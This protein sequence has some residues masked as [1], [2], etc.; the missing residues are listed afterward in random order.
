[1]DVLHSLLIF[2][3][4]TSS[5][6]TEFHGLPFKLTVNLPFL[7]VL[8]MLSGIDLISAKCCAMTLR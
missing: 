7:K 3:S 1:M 5:N 8:I 4:C 2:I 6:A